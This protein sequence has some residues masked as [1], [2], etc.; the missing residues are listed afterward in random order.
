MRRTNFDEGLACRT[1]Q[2]DARFLIR[3]PLC[4][5]ETAIGLE[6][7]SSASEVSVQTH[8]VSVTPPLA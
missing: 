5:E 3:L 2:G 8:F 1:G 4:E 6:N 7:E